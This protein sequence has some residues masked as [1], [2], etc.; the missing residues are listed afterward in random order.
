MNE[1]GKPGRKKKEHS[2]RRKGRGKKGSLSRREK[3][4]REHAVI[5]ITQKI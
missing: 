1:Q 4:E 5:I 2:E 3:K